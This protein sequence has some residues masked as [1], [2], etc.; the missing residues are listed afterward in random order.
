[1]VKCGMES[2]SS[3]PPAPGPLALVQAF[4]NTYDVEPHLEDLH[5]PEALRAWLV[6]HGLLHAGGTLSDADVHRALAAREA[7]RTMLEANNGAP[8]DAAAVT[9][10]NRSADD[11]RLR[12]QFARDG[13]AQLE[14]VASGVDAAL[15]RILAIVYTAMTEG[16]WARLKV[17]RN[18]TCRW[19]FY[20]YSKNRS[21][22]WCT[23][24]VCG[25]R[26]KA[27]TYRQRRRQS[28]GAA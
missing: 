28:S 21:G 1:M 3:R 5:G 23:M 19:A 9:T 8:V 4:V 16:T 14:P 20:D 10:L 11:A 27:R 6:D 13:R 7:L 24:A 22:A 25:C 18:E 2:E 26:I 12:V 17:C 15:G